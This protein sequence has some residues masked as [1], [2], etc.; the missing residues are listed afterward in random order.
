MILQALFE[1]A[2]RKGDEL[3]EDGFEDVE[4]KYLI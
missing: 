4:I 3:P 1:Y 2:Q